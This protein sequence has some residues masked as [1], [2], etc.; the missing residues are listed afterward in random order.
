MKKVALIEDN[1]DRQ[2]DFLRQNEIDLNQY[3]DIL[4]N[5]TDESANNVL[6]NIVNDNLNLLFEYEVIICHKSVEYRNTN[7][8]TILNNLKNYC[9][10][11]SKALVLFSG[12]ISVNYYDNSE[13]EFLELDTKT[14]YS[15]NLKLFLE[16]L[17]TSNEEILMLCYGEH[18]KQN[19]VA[20]TLEK[21][22]LFIFDIQNGNEN[23]A[24]FAIDADLTKIDYDFYIIEKKT[25]DEIQSF[26][27]SLEG[28]FSFHGLKNSISQS[29]IIDCDNICELQLFDHHEKFLRPNNNDDID[30]Y[31]SNFVKGLALKEFDKIFIKDNLS[32]NYLELYGL[33]VAH[34]IRLSSELSDIQ[35]LPIVIISDFDSATLNGFSKEANILFTDG[36]YI[37]KNTKEDILKFQS[38]AL[39]GLQ[40]EHFNDFLQ[41]ITIEPPKDLSGSHDIANQWSIY[42][43]AEFLKVVANAIQINKETIENKIY[44]KYLKAFHAQQDCKTNDILKPSKKGKVL[45]IDDEWNRGWADVI[46]VALKAEGVGLNV[47]EYDFKGNSPWAISRNI[48][49]KIQEFDPDVIILDLRLARRD[50]ENDDIESYSGIKILQEIHKINAGIQVIMLTATSKSTILE[51]LYEKKILG[52]V[53]KEHPGDISI[54]TVDNINKLIGLVDKGLERKYLKEVFIIQSE[55]LSLSLFSN[56][57]LSFD[58]DH[59]TRKLFELKNTL[60]RIFETLDSNIPKPFIY[61]MLTLYKCI[62]TIN[63]YFIYEKYDTASKKKIAYWLHNNKIIDG[64]G[65]ASVKNKI[66]SILNH[67]NIQNYDSNRLI[68]EISCTRNFEIHP[69]EISKSCEGKVVKNINETHVLDWFKTIEKILNKMA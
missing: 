56:L 43:W 25:F 23:P 62:E 2:E 5:F 11:N 4:D 54:D 33:R 55:L 38:L 7:T 58:M 40:K 16:A 19:I 68:D 66:K 36:I 29:V 21:T 52:Y 39:K 3:A 24:N 30:I 67:L 22:N 53:K 15:G 41:Q 27:E 35:F 6:E 48:K 42:R 49:I 46:K 37:C 51:K 59:S 44:F 60:S 8:T 64:N 1:I 63:D 13:F 20:N 65:E 50:H 14:F 9:K 12:G 17:Q 10:K 18:W 32:S 26:Q 61:G 57:K 47:F 31:I 45:L 28:Y 34:H 69:G